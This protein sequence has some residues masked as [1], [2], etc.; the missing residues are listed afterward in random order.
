M[1]RACV[2]QG[3]KW[4]QTPGFMLPIEFCNRWR[5]GAERVSAWVPEPLA[6]DLQ[7]LINSAPP[8]RKNRIQAALDRPWRVL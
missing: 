1:R 3:H 8:R 4:G 7:S 2:E 5:C 6:S